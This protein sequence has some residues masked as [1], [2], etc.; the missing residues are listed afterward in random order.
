AAGMKKTGSPMNVRTKIFLLLSAVL[1][2]SIMLYVWVYA[3]IDQQRLNERFKQRAK[4]TEYAFKAEQNS[5]EMRMLQ[6]A[7]FVAHDQEVQQL[8]LLGKHAVELEGGGAGGELASQVRNALF[9]HV[10]QSQKVL[11]EQFGFRQLQFLFG[12]GAISFLRVHRP[13]KFGDQMGQVRSTV[14]VANAKQQ[15]TMGFET[16][17]SAAGLRGVTPVY[18]FDGVTRK[19]V[20]VGSLEAG[21]SFS[22][23]LSLFHQNRPWLNMSVLLSQEHIQANLS[24]HIFDKISKENQIIKGF[25]VEGTTSSAIKDF[26]ARNDFSR[27]MTEPG[28]HLIRDGEIPFSVTSFLLRDFLG[29]TDPAQPDA[30]VVIIWRDVSAEIAAYHNNVR[31]LILYGIMLFVL[32]ELLMFYGLKLMTQ[33]LQTELEQTREQEVA[34]EHARLIAEESSRLKTQFLSNMSHELRTPMNA[35]MGL[36]QLLSDSSLDNRQRGFMDKINLSSRHLLNLINEIL[37]VAEVDAQTTEE[38]EHESYSPT[39]L[40]NRMVEKFT[41]KA[42]DQGVHLKTEIAAG[43]PDQVDG[44]F[45][46]MEQVLGQLLGNAIKFSHDG[47]VTLSLKLLDQDSDSVILEY[48]VS[49]QGI[50]ISAEQQQQIF[51]SFYQGDGSKTR[52]YGGT[53]LG[54]TIAQKIC[55]QLGSDITV[56]STLGQGSRFSFQQKYKILAEGSVR[57]SVATNETVIAMAE[58]ENVAAQALGTLSEIEKLLQRLEEP[59]TKMQP[60][61]CQDIATELKEKQWPESLAAEIEEL[62]GLISKYRFVE[63]Q[64]VVVRLQELIL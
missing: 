14:V 46:Q 36:G 56:E 54:L 35:I 48:A 45:S 62:T 60:Q 5:T 42:K 49:D 55:H 53:G 16:G 40:V 50:G 43:L 2:C 20:H 21:T 26:L 29:E 4:H 38:L 41:A 1:L 61:P 59:L 64:E 33:G 47:D 31:N 34:S 52:D 22:T 25:Y 12:P 58:E 17:R 23:M 18:A 13:E 11:A 37:L 44:Y 57:S 15:N 30:G 3:R 7:T 32:I 28:H 24:P 27:I 39:Q 9:E 8:F 6:I 10:R 51:E 19:K 63:A